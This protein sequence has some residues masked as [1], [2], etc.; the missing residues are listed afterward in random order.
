MSDE[1]SALSVEQEISAVAEFFPSLP[2]Y[3]PANHYWLAEDG[4]LFSS[5]AG[6][7]VPNDN[8]AFKAWATGG[9]LPTAWPR[10]DAGEQTNA[11]LH[12][13]L[14]PYSLTISGYTA[15]PASVTSAQAKIQ[16]LRTPGSAKDKTLLDDI[17]TAVQAT[18]G[19][20]QIWFTEARTWDRTNPYV[21]SL[22]GPQGLKLTVDQVD[23]LFIQAAKIAA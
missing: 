4:R 21:A 22:S 10:D 19:E 13:V 7:I 3:N 11:A 15:V 23:Q 1:N 5:A 2:L 16:C 18:G 12:E 14:A 6:D 9:R 17:T 20:A 8:P